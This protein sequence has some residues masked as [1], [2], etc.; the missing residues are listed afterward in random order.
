MQL[1]TICDSVLH[2]YFSK[3]ADTTEKRHYLHALQAA[4]VNNGIYPRARDLFIFLHDPV[5]KLKVFDVHPSD[6]QPYDLSILLAIMG[7]RS[8]LGLY[9][10]RDF[11]AD[12]Q[13]SKEFYHEAGLWITFVV[14]RQMRYLRTLSNSR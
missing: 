10:M 9:Y 4:M 7:D 8:V 6:F 14:T 1:R 11:S 2:A 12:P 3:V 13:R 5:H